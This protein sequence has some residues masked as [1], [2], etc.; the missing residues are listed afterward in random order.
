MN[1][2]AVKYTVSKAKDLLPFIYAIFV[3]IYPYNADPFLLTNKT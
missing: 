3:I 2:K 1:V